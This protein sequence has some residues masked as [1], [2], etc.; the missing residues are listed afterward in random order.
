MTATWNVK[1][2]GANLMQFA[3]LADAMKFV[4]RVKVDCDVW[5]G[6]AA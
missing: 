1:Q 2:P 3:T 5:F 4:R 6:D